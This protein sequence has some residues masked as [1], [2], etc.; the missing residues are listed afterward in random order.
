ML[1]E[2][3]K[4][5]EQNIDIQKL[6]IWNCLNASLQ[7]QKITDEEMIDLINEVDYLWLED[8]D[9]TCISRISDFV[10][11]YKNDLENMSKWEKL[12]ELA[13]Y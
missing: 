4:I 13:E 5:K 3:K 2:F 1:E 9:N 12:S 10:V 8:E 7:G 11:E 6:Y